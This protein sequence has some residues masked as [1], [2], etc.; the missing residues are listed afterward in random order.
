L[1]RICSSF[2][3]IGLCAFSSFVCWDAIKDAREYFSRRKKR[4]RLIQQIGEEF[5]D[6][7]GAVKGASR[8]YV[9]SRVKRYFEKPENVGHIKR[10]DAEHF[11]KEAFGHIPRSFF[12]RAKYKTFLRNQ[13]EKLPEIEALLPLARPPAPVKPVWDGWPAG[14]DG[15]EELC[16]QPET[17]ARQPAACSSPA[18]SPVVISEAERILADNI[19]NEMERRDGL[20]RPA[21]TELFSHIFHVLNSPE[22]AR[23]WQEGDV[24]AFSNLARRYFSLSAG[25]HITLSEEQQQILNEVLQAQMPAARPTLGEAIDDARSPARG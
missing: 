9:V 19:V 22:G 1:E 24:N 7:I 12:A 23:V 3:M 5:Y 14:M 18:A 4:Q 21:G 11:A 20:D 10:M 13:I 8:E 17:E 6:H 16:F 2:S 25:K 15:E